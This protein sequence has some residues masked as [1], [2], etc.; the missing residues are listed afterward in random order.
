MIKPIFI[1]SYLCL[2]SFNLTAGE[3]SGNIGIEGRYFPNAPLYAEQ[4]PQHFSLSV[5]PEFRHRWDNGRNKFT[6]VPFYRW[7]KHDDE[8]THGDIRELDLISAQGNWEI[9][10]GISKVYWGV[11]ESQHLVDIINQTD[12]VEGLD[13]EEKLGQPMLRLSHFLDN[14]ELAV[15]LLPYFRERTFV[16]QAGRLRPP[17]VVADD[18]R[19][20]ARNQEKHLDYALRWSENIGNIDFALH[21]FSG[22]ARN[23]DFNLIDGKVTPYYSLL[24][25]IGLEFQYTGDAWLWKL[26]SVYRH[27]NQTNYTV[28][29]GGF[30]Y[31]LTGVADSVMDVGLLAEYHRDS[32]GKQANVALQKD[33]FLGARLTFNDVQST[34]LL[35]GMMVDVDS[36]NRSL[37]LEASRRLGESMLLNL[38]GQWFGQPD[39]DSPLYL[40]RADDYIQLALQWFF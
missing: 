35:A 17:F 5:Q 2:L 18:S 22:T 30:E 19:Y 34:S 10:L 15:Y 11:T 26:E 6:F 37:R 3:F 24:R 16:G 9:Q 38:E 14:G 12:A 23:P 39:A 27:K 4:T 25:Q 20:E 28:A 7:D 33:V 1:V 40:L 36:H 8:R 21:W 13:G 29:V 32:R 31:T